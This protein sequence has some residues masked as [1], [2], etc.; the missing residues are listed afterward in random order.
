MYLFF[1]FIFVLR[2]SRPVSKGMLTKR[3]REEPEYELS[4]KLAAVSSALAEATKLIT[5]GPADSS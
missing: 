1:I 2:S 5:T 3:S 4:N